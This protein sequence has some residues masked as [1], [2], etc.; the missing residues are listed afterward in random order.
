MADP[1]GCRCRSRLVPYGPRGSVLLPRDPLTPSDVIRRNA[2]TAT[3]V[4]G[5]ISNV[6]I[7]PASTPTSTRAAIMPVISPM[8]ALDILVLV[9]SITAFFT[10]RD[11]QRRRGLS[12][13]PGPRPLPLIGNLLDI[14]KEFSWLAYTQLSKKHGTICFAR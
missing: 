6:H 4:S 2:G 3:V 7:S 10:I 9:T 8:S 1:F 11:Y 5:T 14:P 13:P 12:Y